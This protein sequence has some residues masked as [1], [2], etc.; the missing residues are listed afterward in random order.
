MEIVVDFFHLNGASSKMMFK[1][2][3]GYDSLNDEQAI[4]LFATPN[5]KQ[6]F[7]SPADLMPVIQISKQQVV[8]IARISPT[9]M[10]A[11]FNL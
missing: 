9:P 4:V 2:R 5:G 10:Q 1:I 7:T 11:S 6:F 3:G 8:A